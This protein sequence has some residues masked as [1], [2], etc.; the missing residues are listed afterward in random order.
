MDAMPKWLHFRFFEV[1]RMPQTGLAPANLKVEPGYTLPTPN[2]GVT[3]VADDL[4]DPAAVFFVALGVT[5][6]SKLPAP[7]S[8]SVCSGHWSICQ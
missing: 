2:T 5:I 1:F 6:S 7:S 4:I 8:P 3:Q